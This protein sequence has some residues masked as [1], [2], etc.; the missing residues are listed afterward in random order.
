M[1]RSSLDK[2]EV[3][4]LFKNH[5]IQM[6]EQFV[7][8]R[9]TIKINQLKSVIVLIMI[10]LKKFF[11]TKFILPQFSGGQG[12][13]MMEKFNHD[14]EIVIEL[15][16]NWKN[17]N[18]STLMIVNEM[19]QFNHFIEYLFW[20]P[21]FSIQMLKKEIGIKSKY[22][23]DWNK[24][25]DKSMNR[26]KKLI[27][28]HSPK[29]MGKVD[30][31][32]TDDD[33]E[34]IKTLF[35][36][37]KISNLFELIIK[38][39]TLRR[40]RRRKKKNNK[41]FTLEI[42]ILPDLSNIK[43]LEK[44]IQNMI[45]KRLR[46]EERE[47]PYISFITKLDTVKT[48]NT[49]ILQNQT[50]S[51]GQMI[52][53]RHSDF[54]RLASPS[55]LLLSKNLTIFH[56]FLIRYSYSVFLQRQ[57]ISYFNTKNR[58][59]NLICHVGNTRFEKLAITHLS[60]RKSEI[61]WE[62]INMTK[63]AIDQ[64]TFIGVPMIKMD[65]F[66]YVE[67]V[68]GSTTKYDTEFLTIFEMIKSLSLY[69]Y[70]DFSIIPFVQKMTY[71]GIELAFGKEFVKNLKI[72]NNEYRNKS[73]S[74]QTKDQLFDFFLKQ[75]YRINEQDIIGF[76]H[77]V[78]LLTVRYIIIIIK[79]IKKERDQ[80]NGREGDD[81]EM[82]L[83]TI[84]D[85]LEF[86]LGKI[87]SGKNEK[88]DSFL[89]LKKEWNILYHIVDTIQKKTKMF[90]VT[91]KNIM[92]RIDG[93]MIV[94]SKDGER[95]FKSLLLLKEDELKTMGTFIMNEYF[96]N[97]LSLAFLGLLTKNTQIG[98]EL[99]LPRLMHWLSLYRDRVDSQNFRIIIERIT[100]KMSSKVH[101]NSFVAHYE[102]I[103]DA[104]FYF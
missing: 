61:F 69:T 73:L 103:T 37:S 82:L 55:N 75:K 101:D 53:F 104:L 10:E 40:R 68:I 91:I 62:I 42:V 57:L 34:S 88:F 1:L 98:W 64:N 100:K 17:L 87:Q 41:E 99:V 33:D 83:E 85:L 21:L 12:I 52:V 79:K 22:S 16:E 25:L 3:E 13:Q 89:L 36:P 59:M 28:N 95:Q 23:V 8:P 2:L 70:Y 49:L 14:Y 65:Q 60:H 35:L 81:I 86:F 32:L 66:P 9:V 77:L 97:P 5:V 7:F 71:D 76:I 50:E 30:L 27:L 39:N 4:D 67:P 44:V 96:I 94:G 47:F 72:K 38:W 6:N 24:L 31:N 46:I 43:K 84:L 58:P 78:R 56:T 93:I 102:H 11:F 20:E 80:T 18:D 26:L 74:E 15:N 45:Q 92:N 19:I 29:P 48:L 51:S 54:Q 90:K 63:G